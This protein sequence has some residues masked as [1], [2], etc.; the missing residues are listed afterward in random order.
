MSISS[1]SSSY[2]SPNSN[3]QT[4][5]SQRRSE[6]KQL[7]E[8]LQSGDLAAAKKA[9]GSLVQGSSQSSSSLN[10]N[11]PLT[12]EFQTLGKALQSGD[13]SGA[14]TAFAQFQKDAKAEASPP[15][16]SARGASGSDRAYQA[17]NVDADNDGDPSSHPGSTNA[18]PS[19][20]SSNSS[21]LPLGTMVNLLA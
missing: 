14:R 10:Q 16:E 1:V 17:R 6:F 2:Y 21:S 18:T 20:S 3:V 12:Q 8:A 9:Y 13:L 15:S 19:G 7:S 4:S 5:N 11:S